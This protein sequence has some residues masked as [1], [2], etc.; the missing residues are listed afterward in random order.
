MESKAYGRDYRAT[1]S[2]CAP[3]VSSCP[4]EWNT[5]SHRLLPTSEGREIRTSF[6]PYGGLIVFVNASPEVDY[7]LAQ[8][9]AQK[10]ITGQTLET[11]REK[12]QELGIPSHGRSLAAITAPGAP[13]TQAQRGY[14][15]I[16]P[17]GKTGLELYHSEL[18]RPEPYEPVPGFTIPEPKTRRPGM[19]RVPWIVF[20]IP[21]KSLQEF[22]RWVR[23]SF[24]DKTTAREVTN[25][26]ATSIRR[27]GTVDWPVP[28]NVPSLLA[29]EPLHP[30]VNYA[31]V[32]AL[33]HQVFG[34]SALERLTP[35]RFAQVM[36]ELDWVPRRI[37]GGRLNIWFPGPAAKMPLPP[38][39]RAQMTALTQF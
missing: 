17:E 4:D 19:G 31:T 37:A 26:A 39:A 21:P 6:T 14:L 12:G 35:T 9:R 8:Y 2:A 29:L 11:F 16:T 28:L 32:A 1:R 5:Y 23:S 20:T 3:F 30:V 15:P 22:C 36:A 38:S 27:Y 24:T 18:P 25:W 10:L 33:S 34:P 7:L 13:P